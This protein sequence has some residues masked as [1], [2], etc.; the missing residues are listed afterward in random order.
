M[1]V[2]VYSL[3]KGVMIAVM[4]AM[5][6][7]LMQ[8]SDIKKFSDLKGKSVCVVKGGPGSPADYLRKKQK[9]VRL[10]KSRFVIQSNS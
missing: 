8:K 9:E 3:M 2:F 7:A 10:P 4:T 6:F 1:C 5:Q